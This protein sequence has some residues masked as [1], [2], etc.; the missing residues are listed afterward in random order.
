MSA[1]NPTPW[2]I[3]LGDNGKRG[4][5][6]AE[7]A[8]I[9]DAHGVFVAEGLDESTAREIVAAVNARPHDPAPAFASPRPW[10]TNQY[11]TIMDADGEAIFTPRIPSKGRTMNANA[12]LLV[13]AVNAWE[14]E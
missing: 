2:T 6:S 13:A 7:W 9:L 8:S 12:A 5:A 11:A 3:Q 14:A 1:R 4:K 10:R